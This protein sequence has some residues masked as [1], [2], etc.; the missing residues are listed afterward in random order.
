M[1]PSASP[2]PPPNSRR[3]LPLLLAV[4]AVVLLALGGVVGYLVGSAPVGHA[5]LRV[6]IENRFAS[7]VTAQLTV[8][9]RVVATLVIPSS[10]TMSVDVPVVF[11]NENG[12]FFNVEASAAPAGRDSSSVLVNSPG[13]YIVSLRLG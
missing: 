12:A 6:S 13:I 11:G 2:P 5:T 3:R 7:T 10:Q 1:Q 8:N 9:A 4:G